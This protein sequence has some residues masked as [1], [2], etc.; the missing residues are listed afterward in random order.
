MLNDAELNELLLETLSINE[1]PEIVE[2]LYG[3][4]LNVLVAPKYKSELT[5]EVIFYI[6]NGNGDKEKAIKYL[7]KS[8]DLALERFALDVIRELKINFPE[9]IP[10]NK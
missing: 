4:Y 2:T 8:H 10:E 1:V 5:A 3:R 9:M 6:E 7:N